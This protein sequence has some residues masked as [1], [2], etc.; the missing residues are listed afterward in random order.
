MISVNVCEETYI[1]TLSL[2]FFFQRKCC[3]HNVNGAAGAFSLSIS[4]KKKTPTLFFKVKNHG[5]RTY[6]PRFFSLSTAVTLAG[7][8]H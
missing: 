3:I 4:H 2:F 7:T 1:F 6:L 8:L 5:C